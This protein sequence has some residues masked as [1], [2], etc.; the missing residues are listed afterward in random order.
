MQNAERRVY[1]LRSAFCIHHSAFI[2]SP[3]SDLHPPS[4]VRIMRHVG[5][6]DAVKSVVC[7]MKELVSRLGQPQPA[8]VRSA[9]NTMARIEADPQSGECEI[10]VRLP[11]EA[12]R[13]KIGTLAMCEVTS[14]PT[15]S[16]QTTHPSSA[17][18]LAKFR[19]QSQIIKKRRCVTCTRKAA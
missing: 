7:N 18:I 9:V 4:I 16:G 11:E 14:S 12:W 8:T 6:E 5:L 15:L 17:L 10:E 3:A 13:H 2:Y 19:C 1:L